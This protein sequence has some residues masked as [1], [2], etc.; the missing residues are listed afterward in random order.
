MRSAEAYMII[1]IGTGNVRVAVATTSGTVLHVERDD[2]H[3]IKD[4]LYPDALYFE[5]DVLWQQIISLAQNALKKVPG[6]E[7]V[8]I[9]ASSQREGI[10]LLDAKGKSLIGLPN[11]DHR[12][13]QWEDLTEEADYIYR[14]TGRYH[15]SLFSALK[16]IGIKHRRPE[17]YGALATTVSIS[18]WAQFQLSGV[19]AYEHSQAS[20]TLLYDVEQQE[21]SPELCGIFK[22]NKN[23]LP[24]LRNS[25]SILGIILPE[26]ASKLEISSDTVIVV[27]GADTQLA[28]KSTQPLIE[29]IVIVSGT[30]TPV[31]KVVG[32]YV[33]DVKQRTW[34][35]RHVEEN[36]FILEANAGVTGLNYQRLKEIFYPNESYTVIENELEALKNNQCVASLGSMIAEEKSALLKGGFVFKTPVSH[37]LSR[38]CFVQ[39]A[40]WDMACCIKAN[41]DVLNHVS[42]YEKDYVWACGGGFQSRLLR[43]FIADLTNKR[44]LIRQGYEQASVVGG[45]L[46]CSKALGKKE[47][48]DT[49]FVTIYPNTHV[50]YDQQYKEWK[51]VRSGFKQRVLA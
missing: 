20:E 44:V 42:A 43:Q 30:T 2:V 11:H 32:E 16:L 21:W 51:D 6:K 37:E 36:N 47:S 13:R 29:D 26:Y 39:G 8:A 12:G 19:A 18:D 1:D 3:Y 27:G 45:A 4:E 35:N 38:A 17:I 40:L 31:V 10:V 28:V 22:I 34:S 14:K 23:I 5:P 46:M 48:V 33:T 41:F 15:S 49:A 24:P 25:G 9:T 7:I 50:S